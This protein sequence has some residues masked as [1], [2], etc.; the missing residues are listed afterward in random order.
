MRLRTKEAKSICKCTFYIFSNLRQKH[1]KTPTFPDL[2]DKW[3]KTALIHIIYRNH[4]LFTGS[5]KT[6][7]LNSFAET[8]NYL[9][10]E[11]FFTSLE[12]LF[13]KLLSSQAT[14]SV[15]SPSIQKNNHM[16]SQYPDPRESSLH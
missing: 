7:K 1:N 2:E 4:K 15:K 8:W 16:G 5:Q 3:Y 10:S 6:Q 13:N 14:Y 12:S 9:Y 11:F